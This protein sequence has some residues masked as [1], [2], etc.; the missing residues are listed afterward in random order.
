MSIAFRRSHRFAVVA[1]VPLLSNPLAWVFV[2]AD[3]SGV[4]SVLE[5]R[6]FATGA[7]AHKFALV[8]ERVLAFPEVERYEVRP[9]W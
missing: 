8:V 2:A 6:T 3:G 4:E 9:V 7:E 5:A 1:I